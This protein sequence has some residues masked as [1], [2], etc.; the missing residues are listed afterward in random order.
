MW[1]MCFNTC[2][3]L[4][5]GKTA[6]SSLLAEYPCTNLSGQ[7][8]TRFDERVSTQYNTFLLILFCFGEL[9]TKYG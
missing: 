5:N 8:Y 2:D 9:K 7:M 6:R 4:R 1:H 3:V